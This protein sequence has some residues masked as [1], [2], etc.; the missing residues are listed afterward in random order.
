MNS[1]F[2]ATMPATTSTTAIARRRRRSTITSS[3]TP[4]QRRQGR[5]RRLRRRRLSG[6]GDRRGRSCGAPLSR[7]TGG[8]ACARE[9]RQWQKGKDTALV[10][11]GPVDD[12]FV[13]VLQ[14]LFHGFEVEALDGDVLRCLERTIN[15]C[16]AIRVTA[17]SRDDVVA[18]GLSLVAEPLAIGER[19]LDVAEGVDDRVRGVD[20]EQL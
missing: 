17:R 19:A 3:L 13:A 2:I 9:C 5:R 14:H 15:R 20:P 11:R 16:E 18:I 8:S 10:L 1:A 12:H 7:C 4:A 6:A